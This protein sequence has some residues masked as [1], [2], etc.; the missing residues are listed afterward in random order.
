MNESPNLTNAQSDCGALFPQWPF[1]AK[2]ED[3]K[4]NGDHFRCAFAPFSHAYECSWF[5]EG[6]INFSGRATLACGR[7]KQVWHCNL[8]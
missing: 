8:S 4:S 5:S 3:N 7:V 1:N 6:S 2:E